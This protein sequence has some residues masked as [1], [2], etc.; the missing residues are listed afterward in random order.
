MVIKCR[1]NYIRSLHQHAQS[2]FIEL[3]TLT[4]VLAIEHLWP[5][6]YLSAI[7]FFEVMYSIGL[8]CY[9][10]EEVINE[11]I[12]A[13]C[14][15]WNETF[16]TL[17]HKKSFHYRRAASKWSGERYLTTRCCGSV[18]Y[19]R[20]SFPG[21]YKEMVQQHKGPAGGHKQTSSDKTSSQCQEGVHVYAIIILE[22]R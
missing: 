19:C 7:T 1:I 6:I 3:F 12:L 11:G 16:S 4:I 10:C 20:W 8:V 21:S 13:L 17:G 18:I 5:E 14:F 15:P 2:T 22:L 9:H